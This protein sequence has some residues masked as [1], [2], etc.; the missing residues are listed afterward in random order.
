MLNLIS[1]LTSSSPAFDSSVRH[2]GPLEPF[3]FALWGH[4]GLDT[5]QIA[6]VVAYQSDFS[7]TVM[8][9]L[10]S[11]PWSCFS[12]MPAL[13]CQVSSLPVTAG[14]S[15]KG[16]NFRRLP[17]FQEIQKRKHSLP[18]AWRSSCRLIPVKTFENHFQRTSNCFQS[19]WL[20]KQASVNVLCRVQLHRTKLLPVWTGYREDCVTGLAFFW[21][22]NEYI[23]SKVSVL[24]LFA[25]GQH[26]KDPFHAPWFD[27]KRNLKPEDALE[28]GDNYRG[29]SM[30]FRPKVFLDDLSFSSQKI[31][32]C[33][34]HCFLK[35]R[36][37]LG[38]FIPVNNCSLFCL[39]FIVSFLFLFSFSFPFLSR[40]FHQG[41]NP[42]TGTSDWLYSGGYF[43]RDFSDCPDIYWI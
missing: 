10:A 27:V 38:F 18:K 14:A 9:D 26:F 1:P 6:F 19:T 5:S 22:K 30:L 24:F 2:C 43:D 34:L 40:W 42:Y 37:L 32:L 16:K 36:N 20:K 3:I 7:V 23:E 17:W 11:A 13:C 21:S 15:F 31:P 12:Q 4:L 28:G 33:F 41:T 35:D 29:S 25:I 39:W 8:C